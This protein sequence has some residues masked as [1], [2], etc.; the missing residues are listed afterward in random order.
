MRG[1]TATIVGLLGLVVGGAA[2]GAERVGSM[3][4]LQVTVDKVAAF[5]QADPK[6]DGQLKLK[7]GTA[8]TVSRELTWFDVWAKLLAKSQERDWPVYVACDPSSR[9]V[10]VLLPATTD[11]VESVEPEPQGDRLR[12]RFR[13]SHAIHVLKSSRP[14]YDDLKRELEQAK[15]DGHAVWVTSDPREMEILD[16]RPAPAASGPAKP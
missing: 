9:Q 13:G 3:P 7:N 8:C 4:E 1:G 16:V 11:T 6:A 2:S 5:Q 14:R 12:V 10:K 15:A